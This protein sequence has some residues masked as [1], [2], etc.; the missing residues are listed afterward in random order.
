MGTPRREVEVFI[1]EHGWKPGGKY[2]AQPT[3]PLLEVYLGHYS[4]I[5]EVRVFACWKFDGGNGVR[6]VEVNKMIAN[7]L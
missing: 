1:R 3:D 6:A 4:G 7:A 5:F 2:F